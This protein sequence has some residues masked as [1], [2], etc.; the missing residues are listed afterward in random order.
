VAKKENEQE[1]PQAGTKNDPHTEKAQVDNQPI[2]GGSPCV[3]G[4]LF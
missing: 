1:A 3:A 2:T 4:L